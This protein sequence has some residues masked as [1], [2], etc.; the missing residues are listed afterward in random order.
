V[1]FLTSLTPLYC[2][3]S[4]TN[5]ETQINIPQLIDELAES[6]FIVNYYAGKKIIKAGS[7]AIPEL[8]KALDHKKGK[9]RI[10]SIFLLEQ[11]NDKSAI[12]SLI[13]VVSN[14]TRKENER[15]AAA[16][17]LGR[18][19]SKESSEILIKYLSD[20]SNTLKMACI[21]SLGMLKEEKAVPHLAKLT[22]D[23]N[24]QIRKFSIQSIRSIG[25]KAIQ[26]LEKTIQ[27]GSLEEKLL[28]L[29]VLSYINN[30]QSYESL[31]KFM[32]SS[33]K[34]VAISSAYILSTI[35]KSEG[36]EIATKLK[37]DPDPKIKVIAVETLKNIEKLEKGGIK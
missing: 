11:I 23:K 10:A 2:Q 22:R 15:A 33:D 9:V 5:T 18:M 24:E 8:I 17:A 26:E 34:Y 3:S 30:E 19:G 29:E 6:D 4:Q 37:N 35:G 14:E 25:N 28:S 32:N 36:K 27:D 1:I 12:P 16:M 21:I 7:K 31:K 20:D 13:K